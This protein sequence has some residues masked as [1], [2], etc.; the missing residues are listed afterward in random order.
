MWPFKTDRGAKVPEHSY[1]MT[2]HGM[3]FN[4]I[5][6]SSGLPKRAVGILGDLDDHNVVQNAALEIE[7]SCGPE[8]V[9]T[10]L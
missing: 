9:R 5:C 3:E 10:V 8:T 4:D 7:M 1:V 6:I 2:W